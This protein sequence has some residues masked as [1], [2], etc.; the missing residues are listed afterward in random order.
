MMGYILGA[1]VPGPFE[2]LFIF[3][4]G[5]IVFVIPVV[6]IVLLVRHLLRS[7]KERRRL[8]LELG[9]LAD[10]LEQIREQAEGGEEDGSSTESG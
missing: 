10:E 5:L 2:L 6:L 9:K 4:I 3:I 1:F 7:D 8:R